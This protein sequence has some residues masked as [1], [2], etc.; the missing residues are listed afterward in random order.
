MSEGFKGPTSYTT[1]PEARTAICGDFDLDALNIITAAFYADVIATLGSAG[2][3]I[4]ISSWRTKTPERIVEKI[5]QQQMGQGGRDWPIADIY[6]VR[7]ILD[8]S[9]RE[10]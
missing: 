1:Q 8:E 3:P 6:G 10:D 9:V 4:I 7:I 5:N 2:I